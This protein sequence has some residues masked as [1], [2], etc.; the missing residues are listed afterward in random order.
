MSV[1]PPPPTVGIKL[2]LLDFMCSVLFIA[3]SDSPKG[4]KVE[5]KLRPCEIVSYQ[6]KHKVRLIILLN[7]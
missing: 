4:E 5:D 1:S 3:G 6:E 2:D 7:F